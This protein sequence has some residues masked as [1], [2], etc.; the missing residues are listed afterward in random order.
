MTEFLASLSA[1]H[2]LLPWSLLTLAIWL[3]V[4]LLRRFAPVLWTVPTLVF[5]RDWAVAKWPDSDDAILDLWKVVQA[6]PSIMTGALV[7]AWQMGSDPSAAWKGAAVGSL[8]PALHYLLR[9]LP[10]LPYAGKLGKTKPPALMLVAFLLASCSDMSA[11]QR[12]ETVVDAITRAKQACGLY[13][14]VPEIPRDAR[15]DEACALLL[16][17]TIKAPPAPEPVS[18]G[19]VDAGPP[20]VPAR[21][22][23]VPEA[24]AP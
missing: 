13:V 10:F 8:A 11:Q 2:P 7:G 4:Y 20:S 14:L 16:A 6:L 3:G 23:A 15:A 24:P 9:A 1:L 18:S 19:G 22:S 12:A 17:T 21:S 5:V